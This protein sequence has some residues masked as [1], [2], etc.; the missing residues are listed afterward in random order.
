MHI[1]DSRN[2][3]KNIINSQWCVGHTLSKNVVGTHTMMFYMSQEFFIYL[4]PFHTT[5][6]VKYILL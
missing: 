3:Y 1:Q 5:G 2:K 4:V 6:V